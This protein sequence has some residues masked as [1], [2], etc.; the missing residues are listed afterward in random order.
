VNVYEEDRDLLRTSYVSGK[1]VE[2]WE[3]GSTHLVGESSL[4]DVIEGLRS[5][6]LGE[7][8][9]GSGPVFPVEEVGL[10]SAAIVPLLHQGSL[11]GTLGLWSEGTN[12]YDGNSVEM[13]EQ[14]GAQIALAVANARLFSALE[15]EAMERTVFAEI[16]RIL[17]ASPNISDAYEGFAAQVR[18]LMPWERF[19]V[20]VVDQTTGRLRTV[21]VAGSEGDLYPTGQARPPGRLSLSVHVAESGEAM[22]ARDLE[23][24]VIQFP[25]TYLVVQAGL[26]SGLYVPLI[27][28]GCVIGT[29]AVGAND[30]GAYDNTDLELLNRIAAQIAGTFA[31]SELRARAGRQAREEAALAEI[32]RIITSSPKIDDVYDQFVEQVRGLM[33]ADRVSMIEIDPDAGSI[34]IRHANGFSIPNSDSGS[35]RVLSQNRVFGSIAKT[36]KALSIQDMARELDRFEDLQLVYDSGVRSVLYSPLRSGGQTIGILCVAS[37]D[38]GAHD[39]EHLVLLDRVSAQIAG[40]MANAGLHERVDVLATEE[41]VM[42]AI[43]RT[44]NSS[45]DIEAIYEQFAEQV[46]QILKFDRP[47]ITRLGPGEG[48]YTISHVTGF[49][50]PGLE[51]GTVFKLDETMFGSAINDGKAL[52]L[53]SPPGEKSDDIKRGMKLS[54][55]AGINSSLILP[56]IERG[57]PVGFFSISSLVENAYTEKD[58]VLAGRV[59]DLVS[60]AVT[61]SESYV[62]SNRQAVEEAALGEIGRIVNSSLDIQ[63]IYDQFAKQVEQI[64][65]FD[66]I[67]IAIREPDVDYFRVGHV[68]GVV[69]PGLEVGTVREIASTNLGDLFEK[70]VTL[71]QARGA[72]Q[73]GEAFVPGTHEGLTSSV[74]VP[75]VS[76]DEA[77]GFIAFRS[78]ADG[79]YSND[80]TLLAQRVASLVSTAIS[81]SDLYERTQI[82]ARERAV[83]VEIGRIVGSS[84]DIDTVY[85]RFAAQVRQL[86]DFDRISISYVNFRS[87]SAVSAW[88]E[89]DTQTGFGIAR[90]IPIKALVGIRLGS[91]MRRRMGAVLDESEIQEFFDRLPWPNDTNTRSMICVPLVSDG[92]AIAGLAVSSLNPGL[93]GN[94]ELEIVTRVAAQ[95]SG[96]VA[97]ARLHQALQDAS[98]ELLDINKQK[99]ELMTTVAHELR[100]PLTAFN[101]F[102]D[103]VLDR[104]AGEVPEK[105]LNLLQLAS[106]SS[107]RM[108][109]IL[110]AFS[111]LEMAEDTSVPLMVT[112][113]DMVAVITEA[114]DLQQPSANHAGVKVEFENAGKLPMIEGDRRAI[115]QVI[116]NLVSNSIKYSHEGGVV[117]VRCEAGETDLVV[118]VRDTGLGISPDDQER[119]FERFYRGSDPA[120]LHIRGTGLGLYVSKGLVERHYGRLSCQSE[121]GVGSEF[122]FSLPIEQPSEEPA[123]GDGT[124]A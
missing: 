14:I 44:V 36:G 109:N 48:E 60:S 51:V 57:V 99:T 69:I 73:D 121:I 3:E 90:E 102:L 1:E 86:I 35:R 111:H 88:E 84:L 65:P 110:N 55:A 101:A 66:R 120:K 64:L 25:D 106:S 113:I 105:Q 26:R 63:A 17:S 39:E 115:D 4:A 46:G 30:V 58:K 96:A 77:V 6:I 98:D 123:A 104:T 70:K 94:R 71:V 100:S 116:S 112:M 20:N 68:S 29:M 117:T 124:A 42:A 16:S 52:I 10:Q 122:S 80:Q 18:I 74:I 118:S 38:I 13:L 119:L 89:G 22:L 95:V 23:D 75:L 92:R 93:Y 47:A 79:A 49:G 21:Y 76:R 107:V 91:L 12:A 59:A 34:Y 41:S 54:V 15:T 108:Q 50:V 11:I 5:T 87:S 78:K 45:L 56:L 43:G 67:A 37:K 28:H 53:Q 2:G 8:V 85:G 33:P 32:G 82:E 31:N 19:T 72:D 62:R 97:N 27:S 81:N 61:N 7:G 40:A 24:V 103:L 83:L 9:T 114:L